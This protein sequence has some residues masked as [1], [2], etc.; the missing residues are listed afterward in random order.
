MTVS[1]SNY[2]ISGHDAG[3]QL[4]IAS[5]GAD[6]SIYVGKSLFES[7]DD[8]SRDVLASSSDLQTKITNYNDDL[9]EYDEDLAALDKSIE[10]LRLRHEAQ[11][12]AMNAAV[13]SL[14]ETEKTLDNMMEAWKGGMKN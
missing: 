10:R 11:F 9:S 12:A 3:L 2:T 6:T 13:A 14:K 4:T 8:F 1:G 7:L 5:G